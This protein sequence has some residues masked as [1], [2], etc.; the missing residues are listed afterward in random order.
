MKKILTTPIKAEDL[1]D[2][3]VG[4]VIY[5]T[6]T[7]VTCR[8]V[9]HRRLIELKR[10][11]P[12]DLNGKAIFHAGPIVRK[13]GDKWE[14]VSVGPTT[15]MRMESFEREFI[16]QTGVKLVVGKGGMGPLTEEGCQKFKA[17]HVIFPAGCAVLAATQVEEIEEVH[18]TELGMPESLWVCRVKEFGPLIVSID[19]HGNNL[20]AENKA[21][22]RTPRSHRGR[23]L[24][25]RPLHQITLPERLTPLLFRRHNTMKPSTEWW[26][27]LAP[28]AVIAI[29][30]LLPV[31]AG[32]ENHTWLYFAVFTGVIVG[33]ILEPVP[34]AVVAMVG[35]SIIA[36]LSPWLLFSPEQLAQPGFKFTAKSLSWAVSGFSNSVIWLIFAAFMF[37]TGY[38]KTWAWTPHCA[39][40]GEKDGTS[41]AVSR[42]C[43]DV[44]QL[45]LAPVTPSNSA[46]GAG[47]IYPIIRNLPPLYQSQP[48]DSSSRSIGS[49]IMWMGIVADCVT[50]AI[51]L[52]AMAPNLLLIGLMK[53]A[54]HATLSWG[55]WF[56]GMLPLS[57]LLV[58]LVPWLAYVLYPPVLKSGDQVPRWA[59]TELQAMGP[60]VRVKNGCWG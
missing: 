55:D 49:Y 25:A 18:W 42:L 10:P 30:A 8:D 37:G 7:L 54:S 27:Y 1:Q 35:I 9:C 22:R 31:P 41:H 50:S 59:E 32:L 46:R 21:V 16:E 14:M 29:I 15:S 51:F 36:I 45:I 39:V 23:D 40:S 52:T 4:D 5:L 47:I 17:L 38:E 19:T 60:P 3:H 6:G 26:R 48:N 56:L 13:N 53:S 43:G 20:I 24:R 34:G 12:Y 44:L 58:L 28:L 2:I 57:I 11:I 33:L